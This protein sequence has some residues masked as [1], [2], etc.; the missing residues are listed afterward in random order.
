[1]KLPEDRH[2]SGPPSMKLFYSNPAP[3]ST[4]PEKIFISFV[5]LNACLPK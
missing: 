5:K 2:L 1:L 3:M 4:A